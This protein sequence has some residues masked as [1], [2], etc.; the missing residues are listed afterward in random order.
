M[1]TSSRAFKWM[2]KGIKKIR[3]VGQAA[4]ELEGVGD[5]E[6][7]FMSTSPTADSCPCGKW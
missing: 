1:Y 3:N 5:W 7:N 6:Y 4:K 2:G